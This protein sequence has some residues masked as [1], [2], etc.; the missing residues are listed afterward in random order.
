[1]KIIAQAYNEGVSK[2]KIKKGVKAGVKAGAKAGGKKGAKIQIAGRTKKQLWG[3][4]KRVAPHCKTEICWLEDASLDRL[5]AKSVGKLVSIREKAFKCPKPMNKW[6]RTNQIT[7][8]LKPY[9]RMTATATGK[10]ARG[11]FYYHGTFARDES[12]RGF[13]PKALMKRGYKMFGFVFNMDAMHQPGS[14]WAAL[15]IDARP[16]SKALIEYFD[17][18]G[19]APPKEIKAFMERVREADFGGKATISINKKSHQRGNNE[20]GVYA[21]YYIINRIM[22]KTMVAIN[23]KRVPDSMMTEYRNHFY[24]AEKKNKQKKKKNSKK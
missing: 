10:R 11:K 21:M 8:V 19:D 17:S 7:S 13:K 23:K 2:G 18:V 20:C 22:G 16:K 12:M 14:H 9:E 3:D 1:L 5:N 6:L 4:I 24:L 15:F